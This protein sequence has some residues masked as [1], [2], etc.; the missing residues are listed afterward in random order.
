MLCIRTPHTHIL[1]LLMSCIT[2]CAG[3][4][5]GVHIGHITASCTTHSIGY[6]PKPE[7]NCTGFSSFLNAF[8]L[9]AP[10]T[11][12]SI[13]FNPPHHIRLD[14]CN[15]L[16][17]IYHQS[18][19][20]LDG[21]HSAIKLHPGITNM[22]VHGHSCPWWDLP[23]SVATFSCYWTYILDRAVRFCLKIKS[24]FISLK[25]RFSIL[26]LITLGVK[27]IHFLK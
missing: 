5:W 14:T 3:L 4:S 16:T 13:L 27:G 21:D 10:L 20:W 19:L 8:T 12:N 15:I 25:T 22:S 1:R 17:V 7:G 18:L 6:S 24:W 11:W 2:P 23:M 9:I 26:I